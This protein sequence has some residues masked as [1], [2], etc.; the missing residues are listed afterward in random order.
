MKHNPGGIITKTGSTTANRTGAWRA[1]R[2][3]VTDKCTG[4]SICEK[5][6]PDNAIRVF[7]KQAFVDYDYCKGCLICREECPFDAVEKEREKK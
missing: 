1:F 5:F 4:C 2:P 6:C 3:V 7:D